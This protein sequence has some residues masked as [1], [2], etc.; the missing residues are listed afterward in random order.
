MSGSSTN[1]D[2]ISQSQSSKEIT[3]NAMFDAASPAMFGGRRA[4]TC[5]GLTWG[6][7]GGYSHKSDGSLL[8]VANGTLTLAANSTNRVYVRNSG[9][10]ATV[11]GS[12]AAA[13]EQYMLYTVVTGA[14]SV[15]SYSDNRA[16]FTPPW[17][18]SRASIDVASADATLWWLLRRC[19]YLTITGALTVNRNVI[20]PTDVWQG[21]VFNNTSGAYTVTV[22]TSGG[23][24]VVVGQGKRCILLAD[25]TNVVRIT[26]DV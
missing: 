13:D 22:K 11:T 18:S 10:V 15:T 19:K 14:S 9:T 25:G 23:T 5:T 16:C 4:S 1:L 7:Y 20:T 6:Y 8:E 26:A 21:Y 12:T 17:F 3:A 24:G 2:L